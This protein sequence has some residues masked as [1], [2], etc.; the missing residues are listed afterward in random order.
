MLNQVSCDGMGNV[1]YALVLLWLR[2]GSQLWA[3]RAAA[4]PATLTVECAP[5]VA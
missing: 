2:K 3:D 5:E 4:L 1:G